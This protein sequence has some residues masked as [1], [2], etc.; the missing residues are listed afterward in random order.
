MCT[1]TVL[2]LRWRDRRHGIVSGAE[3]LASV[4]VDCTRRDGPA[5]ICGL[6]VRRCNGALVGRRRDCASA[7]GA[8]RQRDHKQRALSTSIGKAT[9]EGGRTARSPSFA[10]ER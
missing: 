8:F 1:C 7:R 9:A 10:I 2:V 5:G 3:F 6:Y 4:A